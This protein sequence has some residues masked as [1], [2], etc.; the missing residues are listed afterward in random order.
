MD[1]L[2]CLCFCGFSPWPHVLAHTAYNKHQLVYT[3]L[4]VRPVHTLYIITPLEYLKPHIYSNWIRYGYNFVELKYEVWVCDTRL[5]V[6]VAISSGPMFLIIPHKTHQKNKLKH[7]NLW[8]EF[9]F[10]WFF[11]FQER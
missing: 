2:E 4:Q 7:T 10:D 11:T 6:S 8:L 5:A 1:E 9:T 3:R